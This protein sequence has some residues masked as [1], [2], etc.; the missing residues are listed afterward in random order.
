MGAGPTGDTGPAGPAGPAGAVGP[1]GAQGIQGIQGPTGATG[2]QGIQGIQGP[3]GPTGDTGP[4]GASY[5][6]SWSNE[7]EYS[8]TS[9]SWVDRISES[10]TFTTGNWYRIDWQIEMVSS[11]DYTR[12]SRAQCK[13]GGSVVGSDQIWDEHIALEETRYRGLGGFYCSNALSGAL[14]LAVQV[15]QSGSGTARCR[16][17]RLLVTRM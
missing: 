7:T 16:R 8:T 14:T 4:A 3:A 15:C 17:A 6:A 5:Q 10:F 9:S 12:Q 2:A 1:A 13:V 11:G